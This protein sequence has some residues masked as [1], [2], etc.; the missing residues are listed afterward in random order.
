MYLEC[1][2]F[3]IYLFCTI[4]IIMNTLNALS[5]EMIKKSITFCIRL[6]LSQ[7]PIPGRCHRLMKGK[8]IVIGLGQQNTT[9]YNK[10]TTKIQ[11]NT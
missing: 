6:K 8:I 3:I 5:W 11:V 2:T 10:N 1:H 4:V 9:K 7:G